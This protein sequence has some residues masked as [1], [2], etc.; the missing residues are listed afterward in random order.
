MS[1]SPSLSPEFFKFLRELKAHNKRDWFLKNKSRYE[2]DVRDPVLHLI[3]EI[4]PRLSKVSPH[5]VV[6]PSPTGGSMMRIYRDTRFSKDKS[7]YKTAVSAHFW[8]GHGEEGMTPAFY[9][10]LEPGRSFVGGG[11]WRP[12]PEGVQKIRQAIVARS[13]A[14]GKAVSGRTFGTGCGMAGESLKRPPAGFDPAHPFIDDLK[15]KDFAISLS[16]KD[17]D[18]AGAKACDTVVQGLK[19]AAPFIRFVTEALG[20]PF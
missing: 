20:L 1:E 12:I 11:V 8:H 16:V 7:P 2:A 6:D 18:L 4:R 9:V 10:H 17:S 15:R 3:A 14:W 5:F 19:S 13:G